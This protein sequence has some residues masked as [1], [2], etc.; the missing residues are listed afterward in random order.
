MF[1]PRQSHWSRWVTIL[2]LTSA[3]CGDGTG[4]SDPASVDATDANAPTSTAGL[5]VPTAP[6]FSVRDAGGNILGGV[7]VSV[8]VTAGGGT[9]VNAPTQTVAGG[10][11]PI[12]TWT[13][14][15]VAGTNTVTISVAG[16]PTIVIT[17]VGTAGP[18]A[19]VAVTAGDNQSVFAGTVVPAPITVQVRDQFGNGVPNT[20]VIFT[21]GNSS[22]SISSA[23]VNTDANG[24]ATAPAWQVGRSAMPQ[25]LQVSAGLLTTTVTA[26]IRSE[27]N[28]EIRFYGPAPVAAA[29]SAFA[30][31]AA[32]IRASVV[33]DIPDF[34]GF[35]TNPLDAGAECG[36]TGTTLSEAVDDVLIYATVVAIDGPGKILAEAGSCI[37]RTASRHAIIGLMRFDANDISGLAASGR[38]DDVVLHEMLHVVGVEAFTWESKGLIA[39]RATP[40][41]RFTGVLGVAACVTLGGGTVCPGSIPL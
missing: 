4:P 28:P 22:G 5:V 30:A 20:P 18:P 23:P 1:T 37:I 10:P 15:K 26:A 3:A 25:I 29:M 12:G 27:F 6:S 41:S 2:C 9:L 39:G 35:V 17:I 11:T 40:E 21:A 7:Q 33:G 38:L 14:G 13:L 8:A 31:A 24:N 19:S 36:V 32:R 34:N 16:L